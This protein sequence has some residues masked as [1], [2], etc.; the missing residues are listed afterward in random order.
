MI[1]TISAVMADKPLAITDHV[2]PVATQTVSFLSELNDNLN[3]S[4]SLLASAA[5]GSQVP[6]HEMMLAFEVTKQ[7]LQLAVELRNKVVEAYQELMR[8]QL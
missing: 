5:S 4:T 8:T 3:K 1:D 2:Q 6:S 7:Q